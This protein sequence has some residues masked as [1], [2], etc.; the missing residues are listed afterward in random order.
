MRRNTAVGFLN[1]IPR[2]LVLDGL[3]GQVIEALHGFALIGL[4]LNFCY[5]AKALLMVVVVSENR[6][7][8]GLVLVNQKSREYSFQ[9][10]G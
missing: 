4:F 8:S 2:L 1:C 7:F 3:I 10:V 6:S 5:H 9:A